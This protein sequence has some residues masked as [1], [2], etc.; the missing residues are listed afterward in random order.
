MRP[1]RLL[2]LSLLLA[3]CG[4]EPR[5]EAGK[6]D[7]TPVPVITATAELRSWKQPVEGI[8]TLHAQEAV[9]VTAPTAGRVTAVQ[10]REGGRVAAGAPLVQLDDTEERAEYNAAKVN[11]ELQ[12]QR[13][14]RSQEL[15]GRQLLSQDE[16]DAQAQTLKEAQ[17]RVN[18]AYAKMDK[19]AIRAPFAGVLGFRQVSPGALVRPGDTIVSLDAID[20]LRAE[21]QVPET[22]L[23]TLTAG[24]A[25]TARSAA[26]PG[27]TF[28]GTVTLVGSRVDEA[29]RTVAVQARIDNRDLALKPG[30]LLTLTAETR[31]RQA[32]FVPES[33]LVP[34]GNNQYLWRVNP[35]QTV[36]RIVVGTGVRM[37]GF[38]EI[39]A[40]LDAGAVVVT[41]GHGALR[42]GKRVA[43]TNVAAAPATGTQAR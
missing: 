13:Y 5:P 18:L 4:Q 23:A 20:T 34:E 15:H 41:E 40:G 38:V 25:V 30:M 26:Y 21:F 37:P 11:M 9:L 16:F 7:D 27:R 33:A 29:T 31:A 14:T 28:R 2:L 22:Q 6:G 1:S 43:P 8:A 36:E 17:A 32:L 19:L 10:F 3:G 39:A 42:P 12:Q 35:G 24:S